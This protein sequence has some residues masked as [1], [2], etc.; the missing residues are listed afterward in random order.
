M[1]EYL[2]K[3]AACM[4]VFLLFHQ[5]LLEKER[6]HHFKRFFL[7]GA[8]MA[9]LVIPAL[10]FTEYV[11]NTA[12]AF[13]P[14]TNGYTSQEVLPASEPVTDMDVINWSL[15]LW[16]IYGLGALLF[17]LRFVK[18]LHQI[19]QRIRKNPKLK[20]NT[21]T[22]V[23]LKEKMP[24]HT[25]F[26]FI[27]LNKEAL[28]KKEI[29]QAV[30]IHEET[31]AKQLHSLDVLFIELLQVI[32]WFNPLLLLFKKSIKLNHE[33]LADGAVLR[34]N[35]PTKSYQN[36]LL[37]FLSDQS[38][39]K[40]QSVEMA[41][42]INYSSI[43]KRFKVMKKRTSKRAAIFR[44]TLLIPLTA[45]L[46][47]GFSTTKE[48]VQGGESAIESSKYAARSLGVEILEGGM[49]GIEGTIVDRNNF[50]K[51]LYQFN[52]DISKDVRNTILNVHVSSS[53]EISNEE[54]WFIYESFQT[55]G[56]YRIVTPHQEIVREK[57]NT[58]FAIE[59][60]S[61]PKNSI[62]REEQAQ[63]LPKRVNENTQ[64]G[65]SREQMKQYNALAKKYNEMPRDNMRILMK[66]VELMTYIYG[67]MSDKQKEYAEPFPDI[68]APPPAPKNPKVLKGEASTI[69]PPPPA[70]SPRVLKGEAS[71]IPP[72]PPPVSP[73]DHVVAM[74]KKGATFFYEGKKI[75]SDKAIE[76][77]KKN[78]D[79][80]IETKKTNSKN[81]K[82]TI[83]KAPISI[84]KADGST[85]IET[86]NIKVNGA[87]LFYTKK[88]G[89]TTY[90]NN[91]GELVD[92]Q[93]Q[94]LTAVPKRK[95]TYYFN[96]EQISSVKAHELLRNNT[97]I[98]VVTEDSTEEEYAV[99][100][101]DLNVDDGH[102]Y[103]KNTNH[104]ALIDL[105]EMIAKGASFY[106]N[107]EPIS[108]EKALWLAQNEDIDRVQ[109][110][111][112]KNGTPSVY[113]WK[114]V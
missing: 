21:I 25:F 59:N 44:S 82:V 71:R 55:Y 87:E 24:P 108:T 98:Q 17:G 40:Y 32:L 63:P 6:M 64:K 8:L 45:L 57:G 113:F 10:V 73:L 90:H 95:P 47:F 106:F 35:I 96:G 30:L 50:T 74:A 41:N 67:I 101:K 38:E 29:P 66:E 43:K 20:F 52:N 46:I 85:T 54:V 36:T 31:H 22:Q 91:K 1:L 7:L 34:D 68:P 102:N 23:L 94:K 88:N 62:S 49:Y 76:L 28:E 72:P 48:V 5:F 92:R 2:L 33:F 110:I 16:T 18:H 53:K 112:N 11:E 26:S 13:V 80:N 105:T 111:G 42:A 9:S 56:F 60:D 69:P 84:G 93:G 81:P 109:T 58:P 61:Y 107:D 83:S 70:K 4:T 15:L 19:L 27:F 86:G 65:A 14:Q 99:V 51:A 37:S 104:N 103:N 97:S 75:S 12:P 3:S 89:V 79:L 77:L 39:R 100:L 114:K 78:K